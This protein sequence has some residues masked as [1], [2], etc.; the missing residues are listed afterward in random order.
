[1]A[2][3]LAIDP[4]ASVQDADPAPILGGPH[5]ASQHPVDSLLLA[6]LECEAHLEPLFILRR[7]FGKDGPTLVAVQQAQ[8]AH[9]HLCHPRPLVNCL[10]HLPSKACKVVPHSSSVE[11]VSIQKLKLLGLAGMGSIVDV[12]ASAMMDVSLGEVAP[13]FEFE[14]HPATLGIVAEEQFPVPFLDYGVCNVV[15]GQKG[16]L[17]FCASMKCLLGDDPA[18]HA[19]VHCILHGLKWVGWVAI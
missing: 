9:K 8:P 14:V 12:A 18:M 11:D 4:M 15:E 2:T 17:P 16:S 6:Q 13:I 5:Q 3:A 10:S 7:A 1:M 19:A